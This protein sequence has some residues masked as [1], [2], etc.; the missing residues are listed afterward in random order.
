MKNN[1][2][3]LFNY[4]N[5]KLSDKKLSRIYG[6]RS[7]RDLLYNKLKST[8]LQITEVNGVKMIVD[9]SDVALVPSLFAKN[10]EMYETKLFKN[11]VK[12]GMTVVDI[13]AHIG[14]YTLL[15]SKL[16]GVSGK[17]Y[18]FD[19][20]PTNFNLLLRN[21]KLNHIS[22]VEAVNKAVSNTNGSRKLFIDRKYSGS[23][24]LAVNNLETDDKAESIIV[25][26]V[27]LDSYFDD[28]KIDFIKIDA[29]GA[30]GLILEGG[31]KT[32]K[33]TANILMEFWPYGIR[34][35]G[36]KPEELLE[37]L[38]ELGFKPYAIN[39]RGAID[40]K[41]DLSGII[42]YHISNMPRHKSINLFFT[43]A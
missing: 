18:A 15:A 11:V 8:G 24:T 19:P 2:F 4:L 31:Y 21:I 37:K 43:K 30:E 17:V 27:A 23:H 35:L 29:Q 6:V 36:H 41:R 40:D 14:Y 22:N 26:T 39:S 42:K 7:L 1:L 28:T 9:T 34:N 33:N 10:Y 12:A 13:G 16:V 5:C 20:N 25:E 3:L 38:C 32:F